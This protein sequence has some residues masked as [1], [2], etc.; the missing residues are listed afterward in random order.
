MSLR[1]A[2]RL[3][4]SPNPRLKNLHRIVISRRRLHRL[5]LGI[6]SPPKHRQQNHRDPAHQINRQL[7]VRKHRLRAMRQSVAKFVSLQFF[8]G[9]MLRQIALL[10]APMRKIQFFI[11]SQSIPPIPPRA[12]KWLCPPKQTEPFPETGDR[13]DLTNVFSLKALRSLANL[14]L[15]KLTFIQRLISIHLNRRK[16]HEHIL[17]R[18]PLDESETFRR[19]KP[20]HHSLFSC[21]FFAP[22]SVMSPISLPSQSA[23]LLPANANAGCPPTSQQAEKAARFFHKQV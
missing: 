20:L 10:A 16:V 2:G 13:L 8:P 4:R 19:I 17:T 7:L 9:N 11:V 23:A 5:P 15:H 6:K 12:Q 3:A 18:L 21:Q 1:I 22:L 14:E